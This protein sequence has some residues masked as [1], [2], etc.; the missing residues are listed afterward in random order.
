MFWFK[1]KQKNRRL[2]RIHVLDVK[3]RSD[4]VRATRVRLATLAFGISFGTLFG[5]Y[6]LWRIGEWTLDRLVYE[7][8]SFSI[9]QV[10]VQT[11]G[12]ISVEQLRRWAGVKAGQNLLALDL[13]T[14]KRN[15]EMA[16]AIK[17][18]TIERVLPRTLKIRVL[19]REPVAQVNVP[20][21]GPE[22][23]IE[24]ATFQVDDEGC[25]LQPLDPRQRATPLNL[26]ENPLPVLTGLGTADLQPGRHVETPQMQAALRLLAVFECSPMAGLV[27]LRRID[28]G[29]PE[30]LVVTTGQGSEVTL[31]LTDLEQQLRRWRGLHDHGISIRKSIAT[32]NLAVAKNS[33]LTWA[34]SEPSPAI[35]SKTSR[36]SR[37]K[38]KNV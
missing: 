17:S 22:G 12:I 25:V 31:G 24:V 32:L 14:V 23:G 7:N 36:T 33:P 9:Q 19:E 35:R 16:S 26:A 3:L 1:R 20:R 38:R 2:G 8:P 27:E 5:L 13:A 34:D 6:V 30:I 15:L 21:T 29:Y 37:T 11:D 10:D 18:A 28:V 4:Q